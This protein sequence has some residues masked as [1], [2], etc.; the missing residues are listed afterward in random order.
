MGRG[1]AVKKEGRDSKKGRADLAEAVEDGDE[2]FAGVHEL[3][4]RDLYPQGRCF[5]GRG[6]G[7]A[8]LHMFGSSE[9]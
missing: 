1:G 3:I 5:I 9:S 4:R 8:A 6:E 2:L 7:E